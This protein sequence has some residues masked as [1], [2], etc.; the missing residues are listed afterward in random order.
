M[1]KKG[2]HLNRRQSGSSLLEA[3]VAIFIF[4]IGVLGLVGLQATSVKSSSDAKYRADAAL[5][6]NQIIGQMWVDRANID[7][8]SHYSGGSVCNFTS[9]ASGL[10]AVTDWVTE[11]GRVLPRAGLGNA[12]IAQIA[13]STPIANTRQV[14][15]TICWQS[16]QEASPHNFVTTAQINL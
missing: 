16:P 7:S 12:Q 13:L 5:L 2:L 6:A 3:V 11:I 8:Y 1:L 4:S 9:S 15:V 14:A 10:T